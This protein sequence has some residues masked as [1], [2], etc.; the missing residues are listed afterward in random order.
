MKNTN[1]YAYSLVILFVLFS[2][3][4]PVQGVQ[5]A[6]EEKIPAAVSNEVYG[7]QL[8]TVKFPASCTQEA[9][10]YL[11]RGLALLH[12]MTYED[13]RNEF[14]QAVIAD[15]ECA[16]GYWGQAMTF[17]H[18]L[19][20]DPPAEEDFKKGFDL[21]KTAKAQTKKAEWEKA[22]ITAVD[23]YYAAGRND[24]EK[25]NIKLFEREWEKVYRQF[26][27]NIEAASLFAVAHLATVD[28][29]DKTFA[30]QKR[31][32][33][34]A[35]K[36]LIELPDHPGAHHYIIHAYDSPELAD[37]AL[38]VA[39]NYGK[40]APDVPHSL[41]MPTH[42]FT[43]L[44]YWDESIA[45]NKRSADAALK[46]PVNGQISL[47]HPHALD[48][49]VYAYLQTGEDQKALDVWNA[50]KALKG[51]YQP[52]V[53]SAYTFAAVPAR[54][55]ME[56]QEWEIA[57]SLESG[58]PEN[59][60]WERFPAMEAITYYAIAVGAAKSGD[61]PSA[62]QAINVLR[63]LEKKTAETS[64]Y[65]G[66]QVEIQRI[67]ATALLK[68]H[69]GKNVEALYLMRQAAGLES[70]TTKH[71]VTPGEILPARELLGDM[72]LDLGH[73]KEAVA[74]YEAALD[75]SANRF[76]SLYGAARAA[77]LDGDKY[78]AALYY[79]KLVDTASED[80]KRERLLQA[81]AFLAET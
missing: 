37:R 1:A 27:D 46:H 25:E 17:V 64:R 11:N 75:R 6:S 61:G 22:F 2:L 50:L 68:Y 41:H 57:S 20:S 43:R 76:N 53:A 65:W 29:A 4:I 80:S 48:Y 13:S 60:P 47:H 26:P 19:W 79:K 34:I 51:P 14:A 71:P 36:V 70:N 44:G 16:M 40:L 72:L 59:Y 56:R 55:A 18:P 21:L 28:P 69:E 30:K 31:A 24:K 32:G 23:A 33:A 3:I 9:K 78:K 54:I 39:R 5:A 15:P 35:E 52:H 38:T 10:R 62:V 42:I 12:N 67:S 63:E 7:D 45:M 73:Y 74:E 8:G 81:K 49:M 77:E 58:K 66:K